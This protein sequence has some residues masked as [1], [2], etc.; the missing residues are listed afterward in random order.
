MQSVHVKMLLITFVSKSNFLLISLRMV[1]LFW[2]AQMQQ[3]PATVL[4]IK[5][6]WLPDIQLYILKGPMLYMYLCVPLRTFI[7][8]RGTGLCCWSCSYLQQHCFLVLYVFICVAGHMY[9]H[10]GV[11]VWCVCLLGGHTQPWSRLDLGRQS[12]R[13]LHLY[14]ATRFSNPTNTFSPTAGRA[15]FS[16]NNEVKMQHLCSS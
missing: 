14:E 3:D 4:Q 15:L 8:D 2:S 11:W 9:T 1:Q 7:L 6:H 5:A 13:Q 16:L 10:R 12:C